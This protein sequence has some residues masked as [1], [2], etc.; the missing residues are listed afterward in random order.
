MPQ[1]QIPVPGT[2]PATIREFVE[3][4]QAQDVGRLAALL[5]E[6]VEL[7]SPLTGAF[8]FHG[9][10]AVAMV[11]SAAFDLLDDVVVHTVTGADDT[12]VV[13]FTA[14]TSSSPVEE[15]QLLRLD[16]QG[17]VREITMAGRPLPGVLAVLGGI[18]VGL[19]KR[20]ILSRSA[21]IA[22]RGMAPIT[23]L[24]GL[25]EKHVMPRLAPRPGAGESE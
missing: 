5:A 17:L 6:D 24:F 25:I 12:W 13:V 3:A 1:Q 11:F 16:D 8:R 15:F 21:A 7:I 23:G 9:R 18:G 10:H 2:A 22:S 14:T 19:H 4:D 20:G